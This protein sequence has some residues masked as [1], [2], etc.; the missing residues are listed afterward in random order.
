MRFDVRHNFGDVAKRLGQLRDD[1]QEKAIARSLNRIVD[2]SRTEMGREIAAEFNI[3]KREVNDNLTVS[4]ASPKPGR[5][6]LTA[7]LA[8]PS[9]KKGRG[10]NLIRFVSGRRVVGGKGA[11]QLKLKIKRSGGL[12]SVRWAFI[13]NQ[14]RTVFIRQ[15][16][17]RLPI[18]ALTTIDVP[19]MFNTK[20]I[21][22]KVLD[23]IRRELPIELERNIK[24]ITRRR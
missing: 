10:F 24:F 16:N 5:L 22:A 4:K 13:G 6:F 7:T 1:L 8:S 19:Q 18:K 14:G 17:K 2:R 15:G 20:R 21:N 12:K 3:T 23:M 11:P 9:R